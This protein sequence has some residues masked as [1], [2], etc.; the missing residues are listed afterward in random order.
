M[1]VGAQPLCYA[2][3][4]K[5]ISCEMHECDLAFERSGVN[6]TVLTCLLSIKN[7]KKGKIIAK[8]AKK[9][10]KK[11]KNFKCKIILKEGKND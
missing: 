2:K 4:L 10:I 1:I 9:V 3:G 6:A 7:P 5:L 8:N 11:Y